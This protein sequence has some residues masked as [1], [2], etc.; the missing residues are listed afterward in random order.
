MGAA[1]T[2]R[3]GGALW[4]QGGEQQCPEKL[5]GLYFI[6]GCQRERFPPPALSEDVMAWVCK[7]DPKADAV[8]EQFK[9]Q[10]TWLTSDA[11]V[12]AT[13][14]DQAPSGGAGWEHVGFDD[15][16]GLFH[17]LSLSDEQQSGRPGTPRGPTGRPVGAVCPA[18]IPGSRAELC[19]SPRA[20]A[21]LTSLTLSK[22]AAVPLAE[23]LSYC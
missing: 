17:L 18:S 9:I 21:E 7:G 10:H 6:R 5:G 20:A 12:S 4:K 16:G 11:A 1:P 2:Q 19:Q 14:M 23:A 8:Q 13:R 15:D 3:K 22:R